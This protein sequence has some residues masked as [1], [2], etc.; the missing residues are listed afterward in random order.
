MRCSRFLRAA[1]GLE[2]DAGK[3]RNCTYKIPLLR[4]EREKQPVNYIP[5][6]NNKDLSTDVWLRHCIYFLTRSMMRVVELF[7]GAGGMGC[8]LTKAGMTVT[9]AYDNSPQAIEVHRYNVRKLDKRLRP[10]RLDEL[11]ETT[12]ELDSGETK[13]IPLPSSTVLRD[14]SDLTLVVPEIIQLHPQVIAGGPPCQDFSSANRD[15]KEGLKAA[16]TVGFAITVAA[17]KPQ[18]FIME[19]VPNVSKSDAYARAMVVFRQAGYGI[20]R[21]VLDASLYGAATAR[22]RLIMVGCLGE[23]DDFLDEHLDAAA[24]KRQLTVR[25]VLGSRFGK[26]FG[27]RGKLYWF[28]AG[29]KGSQGTRSVDR[30]APTITHTSPNPPDRSYRLHRNDVKNVRD[31]PIPTRKQWSLIQGF[32]SNW[33]WRGVGATHFNR[34]LANAVPPPLAEVIGRSV[35]AHSRGEQPKINRPFPVHFRDWLSER[36]SGKSLQDRISSFRTLQEML[37]RRVENGGNRTIRLLERHPAVASL[38][39]RQKSKLTEILR[40]YDGCTMDCIELG[41]PPYDE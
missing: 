10:I 38:S 28:G 3:L 16:T 7:C 8:G 2:R 11:R 39:I 14:L 25:D 41:L 22:K 40:L 12:V 29:G 32:P 23:E 4:S 24:A 20:T 19:N 35:L 13:R 21:R 15:R 34:M 5:A 18:Y 37:G 6:S 33:N 17:A 36:Y 1:K 30:P 31:L 26:K 27:K 9:R